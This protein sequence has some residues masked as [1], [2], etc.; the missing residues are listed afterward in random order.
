MVR[1]VRAVTQFTVLSLFFG[2]RREVPDQCETVA[3]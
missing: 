1:A 3:L 2:R